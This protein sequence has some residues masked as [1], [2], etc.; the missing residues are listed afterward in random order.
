MKVKRITNIADFPLPVRSTELAAA[1][2]LHAA[3][4]EPVEVMPG[5]THLIG[6]GYAWEIP[7]GKV[8]L[9]MPRS[10]LGHKH[11]IILGNGTGV[12][13]PDYKG[14]I[15]ASIWNRS[16]TVHVINPLERICQLLIVHTYIDRLE[17]VDELSASDRGNGGF[18]STG[19]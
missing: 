3:I 9:L 7:G 19:T 1:W 4:D 11:G 18:G 16:R 2:D 10:G 8:G 15:K 17:L 5:Q 14:E 13:D 6:T 12:I